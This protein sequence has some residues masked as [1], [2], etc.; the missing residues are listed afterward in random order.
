METSARLRTKEEPLQL[1]QRRNEQHAPR[2]TTDEIRRQLGWNLMAAAH[3][4]SFT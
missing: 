4:N 1:L 2:P 3:K